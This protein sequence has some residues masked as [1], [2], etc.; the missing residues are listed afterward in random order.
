MNTSQRLP[1][2]YYQRRRVAAAVAL[3]AGVLVII[4]ILSLLNKDKTQEQP[5]VQAALT[6][7]TTQQA[8]P[9]SVQ[10]TTQRATTSASADAEPS[11]SR[12]V[13]SS[14]TKAQAN[15]V[16]GTC[17]LSDLIVEAQTDQADYAPDALPTFYMTV[18]NPTAADCI[19][20]MSKNVMR[21]EV[22]D[23]ATNARLWADVDC[24]P[25][26]STDVE[27]FAAGEERY[28]EAKWS[29]LTSAP[30]RCGDRVPVE[31]GDYFLHT[32]I[33]ENASAPY[34]FSMQ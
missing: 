6:Q 13:A 29:R 12:E 17:E 21:F 23:L 24:N 20:D 30:E 16:K 1:E 19:I 28:F 9:S 32:V 3:V 18:K 31:A 8:Q 15:N 22:Y 5:S 7:S 10:E 34:T 33:G 25:A 26:V 2:I 4:L 27:T 14:T 11:T